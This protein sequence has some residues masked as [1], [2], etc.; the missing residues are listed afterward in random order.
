MPSLQPFPK[1]SMTAGRGSERLALVAV[2]VAAVALAARAMTLLTPVMAGDAYAYLAHSRWL[3]QWDVMHAADPGIQPVSNPVFFGIGR[4]ACLLADGDGTLLVRLMNIVLFVASGLA[5]YALVRRDCRPR[6]ATGL[7][8]LLLGL[9]SSMYCMCFMPELLYQ[10]LACLLSVVVVWQWE[11][12]GSSVRSAGLMGVIGLLLGLLLGTKPH[13]VSL[14]GTTAVL[15]VLR[16]VL[17]WPRRAG[18]LT[19]ARDALLLVV[20]LGFGFLVGLVA[21]HGTSLPAPA[22]LLGRVYAGFLS[23]GIRGRADPRVVMGILG[24]HLLVNMMVLAVPVLLLLRW[25]ASE[26]VISPSQHARTGAGPRP[27]AALVMALWSLGVYASAVLL[28]V[29][30]TALVAVRNPGEIPRIHSRYYAYAI[31]LVI[32]AWVWAFPHLRAKPWFAAWVRGAACAGAACAV[33]YALCGESLIQIY[34]WDSP[35]FLGFS[36]WSGLGP[37]A[38]LLPWLLVGAIC[39]AAAAMLVVPRRAPWIVGTTLGLVFL[40][41]HWN[42]SRWLHDNTVEYGQITREARAVAT[43]LPQ[44]SRD[45][46]LVVGESRYSRTAFALYG[47]LC[48]SKVL[49]RA[50]L[51][52]LTAKDLPPGTEWILLVDPIAL[53]I[54]YDTAIE[55]RQTTFVRLI[56]DGTEPPDAGWGKG[57]GE[58]ITIHPSAVAGGANFVGFHS[59]ESW[60]RWSAL[61]ISR[62]HLP[63]HVEG[64]VAVTLAAKV[65]GTA[66]QQLVLALGDGVAVVEL[67]GEVQRQTFVIHAGSGGSV[68]T[69]R[70]VVPQRNNPWE[71]PLGVAIESLEIAPAG[72][73]VTSP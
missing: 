23:D 62:V 49:T 63:A 70:G 26:A 31:P 18:A 30:F 38:R 69:L 6:D 48:N 54:P 14:I 20:G 41:G 52:T 16:G 32:T 60:G 64:D 12:A 68:L 24:R 4:L 67:G 33:G 66:P 36:R 72:E 7:L 3:G 57:Q 17:P 11:G 19:L 42:V 5:C 45:R 47:L 56:P 73:P 59:P 10:A 44:A 43:L 29:S 13:G 9:P 22:D 50:A 8:V 53:D 27:V 15:V 51:S 61:P 21:I 28:S 35:D 37:A 2:A 46:G 65:A 58:G 40:A 71:R 39:A 25:I 34:P 55:G 1:A